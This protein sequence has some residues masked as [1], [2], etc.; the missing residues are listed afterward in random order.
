MSA[1]FSLAEFFPPLTIDLPE[2]I[3]MAYRIAY[4]DGEGKYEILETKK[5]RIPEL[6]AGA[7]AA[8]L[9]L[10]HL[11]WPSGEAALRDLFIPGEDAVTIRAAQALTDCLKQG[12]G[13]Q[14]AAEVFCRE[15]LEG[16]C[17]EN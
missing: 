4:D 9:L 16:T 7:L 3:C 14:E 5:S 12:G 17:G 8:C 15:I 6:T 11:F 10:T 1:P 2:V 13:M